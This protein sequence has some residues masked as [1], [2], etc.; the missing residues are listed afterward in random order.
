MARTLI[1]V[2]PSPKRGSTIEIRALIQH[3]MNTGYTPSSE[4]AIIPRNIIRKFSCTYDVGSKK[5]TVFTAELFPAI[6]ANPFF[7][8]SVIAHANG[9]LIFTW[10]GD[11]D[12]LQTETVAIR[13]T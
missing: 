3:P 9:S 11:R 1:T 7:V 4:G 8:F 10:E 5:E 2:P 6:A 12:F 13:V